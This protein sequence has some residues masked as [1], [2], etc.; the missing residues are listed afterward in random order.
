MEAVQIARLKGL[1][2]VGYLPL[3]VAQQMHY[4]PSGGLVRLINALA[5]HRCGKNDAVG[6]QHIACCDV[7]LL[8]AHAGVLAGGKPAVAVGRDA[9]AAVERQQREHAEENQRQQFEFQ[10][11]L[12]HAP[13]S[14]SS[15]LPSMA[16]RVSSFRSSSFRLATP[17]KSPTRHRLE[18]SDVPP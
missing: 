6:V 9:V 7:G 4:R 3:T 8:T 16:S 17:C 5:V 1:H 14:S 11:L 13:T 12:L 18:T 10:P 15:V 2:T